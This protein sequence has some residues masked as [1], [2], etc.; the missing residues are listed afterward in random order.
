KYVGRFKDMLKRSG[1]NISAHEVESVISAYPSVKAVAVIPVPHDIRHEEVKA[2]IQLRDGYDAVSFNYEEFMDF[3]LSSLA[4]F[5]VPRYVAFADDFERTP[6][7]KIIKSKLTGDDPHS[8]C[9]DY[10][11]NRVL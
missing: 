8:G 2:V 5:K 1:E 4:K 3:C 7:E 10:E 6:S 9:W 11:T